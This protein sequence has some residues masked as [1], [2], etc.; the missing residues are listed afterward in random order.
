MIEARG[1]KEI[2]RVLHCS[3]WTARRRV[4]EGRLEISRDRGRPVLEAAAVKKYM[5]LIKK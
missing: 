2:A 5:A 1:W 3:V 4:R